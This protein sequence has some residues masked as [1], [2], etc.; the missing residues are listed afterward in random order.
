MEQSHTSDGRQMKISTI[1]CTFLFAGSV[2]A[3]AAAPS[4]QPAHQSGSAIPQSP[5]SSPSPVV[6]TANAEQEAVRELTHRVQKLE[7]EMLQKDRNSS[8][9]D[10]AS[11]A[12]IVGMLALIGQFVLVWREDRRA[13]SAARDAVELARQEAL[14]R[15]AE[16]IL[17]FRL[18]Q[19]EQFYAPMRALLGQSKGLYDKMIRQLAAGEPK[20]YRKDPHSTDDDFR[21]QVVAS[22]GTWKE[23]RLLD[24][25]P[26]VRNNEKAFA[27]AK[28]ILKIG[29]KMTQ[30]ISE[31]AGLASE[32]VIDLL[33]EYMAHYATISTID[34]LNES[35][36]YEPGWHKVMYYPRELNGKIESGY[37]ELSKFINKY[38]ETGAR[39]LEVLPA[40]KGKQ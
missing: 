5:V 4:G 11:A 40:A 3:Q 23:F 30:I 36:P 6:T 21:L 2:W 24:Q 15:D 39:M 8:R 37:R 28:E 32:D 18:K 38:A 17:E 9:I 14:L 22:D 31:H 27:L 1:A 20:R 34:R 19:M 10:A 33:G 12:I 25:L 13:A 26:A 7:L 29:D 35:E 16:K